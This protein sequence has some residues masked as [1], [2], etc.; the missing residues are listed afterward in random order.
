MSDRERDDIIKLSLFAKAQR[1]APLPCH[2]AD[3]GFAIVQS[4]HPQPEDGMGYL[5]EV[6]GPR[7]VR[8]LAWLA[9]GGAVFLCDGPIDERPDREPDGGLVKDPDDG[10]VSAFVCPDGQRRTVMRLLQGERDLKVKVIESVADMGPYGKGS[11][12][13]DVIAAAMFL[14]YSILPT[15]RG[16]VD[17]WMTVGELIEGIRASSYPDALDALMHRG[18]RAGASAFERLAARSLTLAGAEF[19]RPIAATHDLDLRRLA[20]TGLFW[21]SYN[22]DELVDREIDTIQAVEGALNRLVFMERALR[23]ET[24]MFPHLC[25]LSEDQCARAAL[26][27]LNGFVSVLPLLLRACDGP[28]PFA[29][30][31]GVEAARGGEWDVRTRFADA[32]ERL[33]SPFC[34]DYRFDCDARL[35]VFAIDVTVPV[36]SA[37]PFPDE[38]GRSRARAV[39]T[40]RLSAMLAAMAFGA[41]VGIVRAVV[42]ARERTRNGAVI[43]S[44]AF[45]RRAFAMD[46]VLAARSGALSEPDLDVPGLLAILAPI[47]VRTR[48]EGVDG[49]DVIEP[50]DPQL[51]DRSVRMAKDERDLPAE[52]ATLLRADKVRDLDIFDT[53][54]DPLRERFGEI[55]NHLQEEDPSALTEL[56]DMVSTYEAADSL[57]DT[58]A[59]PLYCVNMVSRILVGRIDGDESTRYRK[60]PDTAYDAR[61]V[62]CRLYRERGNLEDALELGRK[63]VELAPTSFCSHHSLALV[64]KQMEMGREAVEVLVEGLKFAAAPVDV[65]CGYY[66]LGFLLWQMGEPSL[67]LACYRI[68]SRNS[69]FHDDAQ[70]EMRELM[71]ESRIARAPD[72][73]EARAM[74]RAEGIPLAPVPSLVET[75]MFAAVRLVESGMFDAASSL[76]HFLSS[77]DIAPGSFDVIASVQRSLRK[78]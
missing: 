8:V 11:H 2:D 20:S 75:A 29:K 13:V 73:D 46:V 34:F 60:I 67:G 45:G 31:Q 47:E 55:M 37:F 33:R 41:G 49:P 77:V 30:L 69:Q 66:R 63:L 35:G 7:R 18:E 14:V 48:F 25:A 51:P 74:L 19:I 6:V 27:S 40:L 28:N 43:S 1:L 64:Y 78:P 68:V 17:A 12:D 3:R 53:G 24:G 10:E 44:I 32:A 58:D 71:R 26:E 65:A 70:E 39:Y 52:L 42:T 4:I 15:E 62:L 54:D 72:E 9:S 21:T 23:V 61:S 57:Q 16:E 38:E 36:S 76:V 5:T 56:A 59:R 50:I 22:A